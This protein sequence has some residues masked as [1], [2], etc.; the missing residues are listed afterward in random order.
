MKHNQFL[1]CCGVALYALLLSTATHSQG[2]LKAKG[3]LIV[4]EK[5]NKVILRGMGLGGWMLQEGYMFR[6][7]N[8][9]QQHNIRQRI[10]EVAGPEYAAKFYDKWL[11]NHTRKID[12]DSMAAWGFNSIRLPMHYNLYT[13]PVDKEPVAG[14]N[15]WVEKGFAMTDSLVK[16]CKAAHIYLILDLHATPGGQGNDLPISDRYPDKP[17]L[18]ESKANQ[19]KM[20]ALWRKLAARYAN[21]PTIG[22][23]DIINEPNSRK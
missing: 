1:R 13:L 3:R 4:D 9:G 8:L 22:G 11:N 18:W 17:S 21:E 15:T 2:F 14:Q 6:L 5:G 23:Y 10:E 20:I 7:S 16:W 19:Q 12:I